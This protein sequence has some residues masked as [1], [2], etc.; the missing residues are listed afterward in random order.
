MVLWSRLAF[1][2]VQVRLCEVRQ[3]ILVHTT[4]LGHSRFMQIPLI[5]HK[6][7]AYMYYST[8]TK[9]HCA[10]SDFCVFAVRSVMEGAGNCTKNQCMPY[11][12]SRAVVQLD[13]VVH[14]KVAMFCI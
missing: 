2:D 12:V 5:K 10:N 7:E 3:L 9:T 6:N 1:I 4:A 8:Y 11:A 14:I 13:K